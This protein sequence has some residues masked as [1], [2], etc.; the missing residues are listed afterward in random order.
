MDAAITMTGQLSITAQAAFEANFREIHVPG[1]STYSD[2]PSTLNER[3]A[4]CPLPTRVAIL[5]RYLDYRSQAQKVESKAKD[6]EVELAGRRFD[7]IR[8]W[9][10]YRPVCPGNE[11]SGDVPVLQLQ[12]VDIFFA[13]MELDSQVARLEKEIRTLQAM[14]RLCV[15]QISIFEQCD[16]TDEAG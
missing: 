14:L 2:L 9:P 4:Q 13:N 12:A 11:S 7:L 6:C 5:E 15:E 3:M 16:G 8:E 10:D 1:L